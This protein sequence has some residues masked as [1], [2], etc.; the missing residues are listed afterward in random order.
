MKIKELKEKLRY[1]V[2]KYI[3]DKTIISEI[4]KHIDDPKAKYVLGEIERY[5]VKEYSMTD[6]KIIKDIYFYYC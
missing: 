5:K 6:K 1:L 4:M 2:I 3:E